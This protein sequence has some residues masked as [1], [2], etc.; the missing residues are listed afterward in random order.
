V[1]RFATLPESSHPFGLARNAETGEIVVS[2]FS[3]S[4]LLGI[5]PGGSAAVEFIDVDKAP[6]VGPLG[7]AVVAEMN[8]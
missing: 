6:I 8:R 4:G 5:S 7:A 3:R 2:I 1:T